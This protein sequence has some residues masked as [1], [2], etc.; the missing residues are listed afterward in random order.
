MNQEVPKKVVTIP[1]FLDRIQ[2]IATSVLINTGHH[3][4]LLVVYWK[5][6]ETLYT[7]DHYIETSEFHKY[8]KTWKDK[9]YA[10]I[11]IVE[12]G[13]LNYLMVEVWDNNYG[14]RKLIPFKVEG[15]KIVIGERDKLIIL[16]GNAK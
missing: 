6:G 15:G 3:P 1:E 12:I 9:D 8:L 14:I 7:V 5:D 4:G 10:L 11:C 13:A 16:Q 2:D